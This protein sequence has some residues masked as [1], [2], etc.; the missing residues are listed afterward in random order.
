MFESN[1]VIFCSLSW[2]NGTTQV[3]DTRLAKNY[4]TFVGSGMPDA[5]PSLE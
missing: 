5:C 2:C 1:N 4:F 3:R